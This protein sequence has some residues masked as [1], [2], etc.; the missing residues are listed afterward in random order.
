[1]GEYA[2]MDSGL[3]SMFDRIED[4]EE[5][6]EDEDFINFGRP[7]L[8]FPQ[9]PFTKIFNEKCPQEHID[10]L[11]A[12]CNKQYHGTA[13]KYLFFSKNKKK[14]LSL[15]KKLLLE[16]GLYTAKVSNQPRNGSYVLC[17]YDYM[18]RFCD[19]MKA[20]EVKKGLLKTEVYF[21]YWKSDEKTIKGL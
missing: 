19:E 15:G 12:E 20:Y 3:Y 4:E 21:R 8:R 5:W 7:M 18:N 16:F 17:V 9:E 14:L 1:M 13:G 2:D 6:K 11:I 10:D